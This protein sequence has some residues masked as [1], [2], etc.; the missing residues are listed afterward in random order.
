MIQVT[1]LKWLGGHRLQAT[2][3]DGTAGEY[4][5]AAIVSEGGPM[6]E[7]LRDPNYFG[8]AFLDDGAPTWPNGFDAV[9]GWLHR[10]IEAIGGLMRDATI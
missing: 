10:E 7:P 5:F 3:S 2:F 9:P 1:K 8:R 4:D 6:A